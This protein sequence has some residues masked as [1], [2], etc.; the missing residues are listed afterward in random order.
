M[1]LSVT[2]RLNTFYYVEVK[3]QGCGRRCGL[4]VFKGSK[5]DGG[6]STEITAVQTT[7][8]LGTDVSPVGLAKPVRRIT[9]DRECNIYKQGASLG[10]MQI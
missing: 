2:Y 3:E 10:G 8:P 5:E 7:G 6:A 9:S 4:G 1:A